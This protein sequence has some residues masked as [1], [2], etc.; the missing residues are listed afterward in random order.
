[1]WHAAFK[2]L[3]SGE[4]SCGRR[5]STELKRTGRKFAAE[6]LNGH[7]QIEQE[8]TFGVIANH[9]LNPEKRRDARAAR[10]GIDMMKTCGRVK[11]Q[12]AGRKLDAVRSIVIF[13]HQFTAFVFFGRGKKKGSGKVRSNAVP[14]TGDLADGIVDMGA[15]GLAALVAIKERRKHACGKAEEMNRAFCSRA[16]RIIAPNSRAEPIPPAIAYYLW[17][18]PIDGRRLHGH[19]PILPDREFVWPG[20]SARCLEH[21]VWEVAS[22]RNSSRLELKLQ[23]DER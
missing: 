9:A 20:Q 22:I 3:P 14:R 4:A 7:I 19:P 1:M 8:R 13:H 16:E 12:V 23:S 18:E 5:P 21:L 2:R 15:K 6:A 10:H 11:N 17:R